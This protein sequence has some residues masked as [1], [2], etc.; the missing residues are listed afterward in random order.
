M[1]TLLKL[2]RKTEKGEKLPNTFYEA[3][4]TLIPKQAKTSPKRRTIGQS[5]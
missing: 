2:F 4:I 1:T 5:P 3:N